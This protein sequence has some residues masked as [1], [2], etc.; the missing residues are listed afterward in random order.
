MPHMRNFLKQTPIFERNVFLNTWAFLKD[1]VID[2][3]WIHEFPFEAKMGLEF[4]L[5]GTVRLI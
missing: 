5:S 2:F 3:A 1:V 4:S